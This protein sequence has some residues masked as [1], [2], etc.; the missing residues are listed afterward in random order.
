MRVAESESESWW[1][2][3][4]PWLPSL[5][6][7]SLLFLALRRSRVLGGGLTPGTELRRFLQSATREATIPKVRFTD[8]AGQEN[9]KGEVQELVDY[10]RDPE[11]F[12]KVGAEVP[13]GVLLMG[14]PGTGKTMLARR[15]PTIIPAMAL[16]ESALETILAHSVSGLLPTGAG[17]SS[18]S[19]L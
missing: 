6:L 1:R 15:L 18:L 3:I 9:A 13:R 19:R 7:I 2:A 17:V 4:R 11:R 12:Q 16:D 5:I 8:I 10:L 14:P